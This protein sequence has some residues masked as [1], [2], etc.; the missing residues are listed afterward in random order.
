MATLGSDPFLTA[1]VPLSPTRLGEWIDQLEIMSRYNPSATQFVKDAIHLAYIRKAPVILQAL[2]PDFNFS[3][4][5]ENLVTLI[6]TKT[7]PSQLDAVNAADAKL[8]SWQ[9]IEPPSKEQLY[10]FKKNLDI[11]LPASTYSELFNADDIAIDTPA[12]D[13]DHKRDFIALS[14]D[15]YRKH[16]A[17]RLC[18][19]LKVQ[20]PIDFDKRSIHSLI[21][22]VENI[23]NLMDKIS[24]PATSA[25]P[26]F[27]V[28]QQLPQL[29]Y[30]ATH[31]NDQDK[32]ERKKLSKCKHCRKVGHSEQHC[33]KRLA[34]ERDKERDKL[35]QELKTRIKELEASKTGVLSD[36]KKATTGDNKKGTLNNNTT[37]NDFSATDPHCK[38]SSPLPV[39]LSSA[40]L[41][42]QTEK[43]SNAWSP[44]LFTAHC[45]TCT[46][47]IV[48]TGCSFSLF[49]S[50]VSPFLVN[51]RAAN[52]LYHTAAA[53]IICKQ[54]ADL[55]AY[56]STPSGELTKITITGAVRPTTHESSRTLLA[57]DNLVLNTDG[58]GPNRTSVNNIIVSVKTTEKLP[59]V[60]ICMGSCLADY[61]RKKNNS[62]LMWQQA[63]MAVN[64]SESPN[65]LKN[66][67]V[68]KNWGYEYIFAFLK[69]NN[70][71]TALKNDIT[72]RVVSLMMQDLH[73]RLGHIGADA[74][75]R[76]CDE[77]DCVLPLTFITEC[78]KYCATCATKTLRIRPQRLP[79]R[80]ATS[81]N[82]EIAAAALVEQ[83]EQ[84]PFNQ[85]VGH[86][87][88]HCIYQDLTFI[89]NGNDGYG[90]YTCISVIVDVCTRYCSAMPLKEKSDAATHLLEWVTLHGPP[91]I[92]RTDNGTEFKGRYAALC[93]EKNILQQFSAPYMPASNG[94]V[95]RL[96][97][98]LKQRIDLI[99]RSFNF[100]P[101]AWPY[102]VRS[103]A[104][105]INATVTH[106]TGKSP[107][108][109]ASKR[110]PALLFLPLDVVSF[111][112]RNPTV[113]AG[114]D[115]A[116]S[117]T[118]IGHFLS[119]L[120]GRQAA[121]L[122][123]RPA[124][125]YNWSVIIVPFADLKR[126]PSTINSV[127]NS[128]A[129]LDKI[130]SRQHLL[131]DISGNP[132]MQAP[133]ATSVFVTPFIEDVCSEQYNVPSLT[134]T[135]ES[136]SNGAHARSSVSEAAPA[137]EP[138]VQARNN[139]HAVVTNDSASEE[140][141]QDNHVSNEPPL[142]T[143]TPP[144]TG[145][146][147]VASEY[148]DSVND[149]N[150]DFSLR[151]VLSRPDLQTFTDDSSPKQN[152]L[153][154]SPLRIEEFNNIVDDC[155]RT[156]RA[157]RK[158]QRSPSA[159]SYMSS[160]SLEPRTLDFYFKNDEFP[161]NTAV[162]GGQAHINVDVSDSSVSL[163]SHASPSPSNS[164]LHQ[165]IVSIL[166]AP[167]TIS[168]LPSPSLQPI[169]TCN[170]FPSS[171]SSVT[172]D[173]AQPSIVT[174]DF[175][176]S[177]SPIVIA[178]AS[179]APVT[180]ATSTASAP[181][182]AS[183]F[184]SL[185]T[186]VPKRAATGL[187]PRPPSS[188]IT[189][190]RAA[191]LTPNLGPARPAE[192]NKSGYSASR[193]LS[194]RP[195][196]SGAW[197]DRFVSFKI[198][199]T[200][201]NG[202]VVGGDK[203]GN[204]KVLVED[205]D[206]HKN[207]ESVPRLQILDV[208][209][210]DNEFV[211]RSK[212]GSGNNPDDSSLQ[213]A[214]S[215]LARVVM[216]AVQKIT[217]MFK[218]KKAKPARD[219]GDDANGKTHIEVTRED[220]RAGSHNQAMLKELEQFDKLG[221]F[222]KV[223]TSRQAAK[224]AGYE[225]IHTRWVHSWK[226]DGEGNRVAKSRTVGRG[227][228]DHS[229]VE[230][231]VALPATSVMRIAASIAMSL[232]YKACTVDICTAFLNARI[233]S[234]RRIA[235]ILPDMPE[236][237]KWKQ[238]DV[239]PLEKAMY[240]LKDA[241][242]IFVD[243]LSSLLQSLGYR[244]LGRGM[245]MNNS[246]IIVAY[247]DDL[248]IWAKDPRAVVKLISEHVPLGE[249]RDVNADAQR[250]V[251]TGISFS[252]NKLHFSPQTYIDGLPKPEINGTFKESDVIFDI[253]PDDPAINLDLQPSYRQK[254]GWLGW[255]SLNHPGFAVHFS[256]L[257]RWSHFVTPA[258]H[259]GV[260]KLLRDLHNNPVLSMPYSA[261]DLQRAELRV[262]SDAS[263]QRSTF[264][265][266]TGWLVQLADATTPIESSDN[267]VSWKSKR[268]QRKHIST[269]SIELSAIVDAFMGAKD[270][271]DTLRALLPKISFRVRIFTD[272]QV[273]C[274]QLKRGKAIKNPFNTHHVE[275]VLQ[276]MEE[277]DATVEHVT[278]KI[279][280][281]DVLTKFHA[282]SW[283]N[284]KLY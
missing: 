18:S 136:A 237:S 259:A 185:S 87:F 207:Y 1:F 114:L 141:F 63:H 183:P 101:K 48:D 139:S 92:S 234:G 126:L 273:V 214:L 4:S 132:I 147:P 3:V 138:D 243:Y 56:A 230:V 145:L 238:G 254:V 174:N 97:H 264:S 176:V 143:A 27:P 221:V 55:I 239:V 180:T 71:K 112:S 204:L 23:I 94:R 159:D 268:D 181:T 215:A 137:L 50:D 158:R 77:Q 104:E 75:K 255:I 220:L 17:M 153:N 62:C 119:R 217:T 96:N 37:N 42:L 262:W 256:E 148:S 171:P 73:Q 231:Y 280:K 66:F 182:V 162:Q 129:H 102:F 72:H 271:L 160:N 211:Q 170:L 67:A 198:G 275:L 251:G 69:N 173:N 95:E 103:A 5:Q 197:L 123:A 223:F 178:P 232:G 34:E 151:D 24:G 175:S 179:A 278:T 281:A 86:E 193:L 269:S 222:G 277:L 134:T 163:D 235:V 228:M 213:S 210:P 192:N 200:W 90:G 246:S 206:L 110:W 29:G 74:L 81:E 68:I 212:E 32:P 121:V 31:D 125:G 189:R 190:S 164:S 44:D 187:P 120:P 45:R 113:Q 15:R 85:P 244:D 261:I 22:R 98:T 26:S 36:N 108:F 253:Q 60:D 240:G 260:C 118:T 93:K 89:K 279:M 248:W 168:P 184:L 272:A 135:T 258:T 245:F 124:Y 203:R 14:H 233:P 28:S 122:I 205:R 117:R 257:S 100:S 156:L 111:N 9:M 161:D 41:P 155:R 266:R 25:A 199:P 154:F 177:A 54:I 10:E 226:L 82:A 270:A 224:A 202:R 236:G 107:F 58:A 40:S 282:D 79:Q 8:Q 59:L 52:V 88:N 209:D 115:F 283:F 46:S 65:S 276:L 146:T 35:L 172:C 219:S 195:I 51:H 144:R 20:L 43:A 216:P 49:G 152:N 229:E 12:A 165:S 242:K 21:E 70:I 247:V 2:G 78:V 186:A 106:T 57:A 16:F 191:E 19:S 265:G 252:N 7:A 250:Y 33:Y 11:V 225:V 218:R 109:S 64:N 13:V 149:Q 130:A 84:R 38:S 127:T 39:S 150:N 30:I 169:S 116:T 83:P 227:D 47:L 188:M 284:P 61:N 128:T 194:E 249:P 166:N 80:G 99:M 167:L 142:E 274:H 196:D 241:P 91:S 131:L 201:K 140:N 76:T 208:H 133:G 53:D 157:I 267:I 263:Y 6:R 105:I